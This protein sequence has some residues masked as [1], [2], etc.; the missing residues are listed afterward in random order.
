MSGI[1]DGGRYNTRQVAPVVG[2]NP[3]TV[4]YTW[5]ADGTPPPLPDAHSPLFTNAS[6]F[7]GDDGSVTVFKVRL[8]A[9]SRNGKRVGEQKDMSFTIDLKPPEVP[10]LTG[11]PDGSRYARPVVLTADASPPGVVLFYSSATDGADAPDP[12]TQGQ[13]VT[14]PLTFDAP[15][16]VRTDYVVRVASRDDAG[17]RSLYD[18]RYHFS[19][20]RSIPDDPVANGA[21]DSGLTDRPVSI[22]LASASPTIVYELADDGSIPRLPT[23]SSTAYA[24]P[25]I[26]SG[27]SGSSVTY[28]LLARAFSELGT[29]SRAARIVTVT[30]DRSVPAAPAAPHVVYAPGNPSVAYLVWDAPASGQIFY[31]LSA[32]A[33]ITADYLQYA[34]PVSVLIATPGGSTIT[35]DAVVRSAAGAQSSPTSF[36]VPVGMQLQPPVVRGA[37]DGAVLTQRTELRLAAPAGDV[38][39]EIST[40]GNYPPAVTAGSPVAPDPL[41]LDAA[42]GQTVSVLVAARAFDPTG[43]ALPSPETHFGLTIDKT[44]PDPPI[45]TGIEDG[46]YYQDEQKVTLLAPEGTIYYSVSTGPDVQLP[47]Q[48]SADKY[49]GELTLKAEPGQAVS[50]RIVAFTV[51]DAGNRSREIRSWTVTIDQEIVYVSPSGNDYAEGSR[52]QPVQSLGRALELAGSSSRKTILAA[53]GDYVL[54]APVEVNGDVSIIGGMDP[55]TWVSLGFER[56]SR[57]AAGSGW[58]AGPALMIAKGGKLALRGFEL[59]GRAGAPPSL[60]AVQGGAVSAEKISVSLTD[61]GAGSGI[62]VSGGSLSLLNSALRASGA[63]NGSLLAATGGTVTVTG[64]RFDGPDQGV[65]FA[66]LD[67]TDAKGVV[68]QGVTINP[69]SGQKTRGIRG[70]RAE[71]SLR[72]SQVQSGAGSLEAV[73]V[74]L[75]DSTG[76]VQNTD[77]GASAVGRSPAAILSS[78][79][80]LQVSHSTISVAGIASAVGISARGGDLIVSRSTVRGAAVAEYVALA[81][82]EDAQSLFANN[83]LIGGNAGESICILFKGGK[84]DLV[85]NTIIAGT[86]ATLTAALFVQGDQVPRIINNIIAHSGPDRGNALMVIG[87]RAQISSAAGTGPVILTN[88]FSGWQRLLHVDYAQGVSGPGV[89]VPDVGALNAADGDARAGAMRGNIAEPPSSSF[90]QGSAADYRLARGSAC[91]DAGSDVTGAEGAPDIVAAAGAKGIQIIRDFNESQRPGPVPMAI[92]GPAR[93]WDIGAYE[94]SD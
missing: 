92:P 10:A 42:D 27:R 38:R 80:S 91:I 57:L 89:D 73:A 69:G 54:N 88:D 22:T 71:L 12:L 55:S 29:P 52:V 11:A 23:P 64:T 9:V 2:D 35:G 86:G 19:V 26:L 15:E 39:Y 62:L 16:G 78:N 74:D 79:S 70:L 17:N 48:T 65:D 82:V 31:R 61:A 37:R 83:V 14:G 24:S 56:W 93:G 76:I 60:L 63:R 44:P 53:A 50:Y 20:D 18:R 90:R 51:D 33:G 8:L 13:A 84:A 5:S 72:D 21:P 81:R 1:A 34:G 6:S 67:L 59:L 40:D 68:L 45:A 94:Y 4:H 25:I 32:A 46:G 30:V 7:R 41:V 87:A 36:S 3:W 49:G 77:V 66:C 75:R 28:R 47:S 85:N 58:K 43:A